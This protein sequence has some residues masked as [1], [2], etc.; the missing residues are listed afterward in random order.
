M[1][2]KLFKLHMPTKKIINLSLQRVISKQ[3]QRLDHLCLI[4]VC[5]CVCALLCMCVCMHVSMCIACIHTYIHTYVRT[6]DTVHVVC[7]VPSIVC[8]LYTIITMDIHLV[9][10]L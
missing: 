7:G 9:N 3:P 6:C 1:E 10:G 5:V 8:A 4:L 2:L